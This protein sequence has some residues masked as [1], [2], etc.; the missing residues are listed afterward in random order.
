MT[1]PLRSIALILA[2]GSALSAAAQQQTVSVNPGASSIAFGLV[3]TGHEVHGNF[4]VASGVIQFDPSA[5]K[6]SGTILVSA[7]S[8][9]SGDKGRDKKMQSDVLDT[10]HFADITFRPVSYTGTLAASGDSAIQVAGVFTLHGTPHDITV[11][12]QVHIDGTN[13]SAKGSFVVPYVKWGLKDPSIF[14]LKVAKEVRI[15]LNLIG[16]VSPAH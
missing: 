5:S 2:L 8:G 10:D 1:T 16:T 12:M 6:I 7:T 3:G 4:H 14:I 9:D 13:A 15:D 11:P